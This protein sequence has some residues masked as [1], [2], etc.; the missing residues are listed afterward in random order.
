MK[1]GC[2]TKLITFAVIIAL[3]G[4]GGYLLLKTTKNLNVKWGKK[5]Y[6]SCVQKSKVKLEAVQKLNIIQLAEGN[7]KSSGKNN[8]EATYTNE[9]ISALLST[10][11]NELG[12]IKDVKVKFLGNN[13]AEAT[14]TVTDRIWDYASKANIKNIDLVKGKVNN[15]PVY[16]KAKVNKASN[17]TVAVEIEKISVGRLA[18][19]SGIEKEV[20]KAVVPVIND[21]MQKYDSFSMEQLNFDNNGLHFKGT[22]P[23]QVSGA[24]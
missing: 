6:D 17:K 22:L 23:A 16:L 20:E 13:E 24:K 5:D 21:I 1:K 3:L 12:P 11:N 19:P 10:T 15:L 2:L 7:F 9:E 8:V 14:F 4:G 18:L